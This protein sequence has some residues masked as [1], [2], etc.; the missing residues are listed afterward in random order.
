ML[1]NVNRQ[2]PLT[3]S[4]TTASPPRLWTVLFMSTK[5][6]AEP[7]YLAS[8]YEC[9]SPAAADAMLGGQLPGYVYARDGHPNAAS[10]AEQCRVYHGAACAA[11]T[12]SGMSAMALALLTQCVTGDHVL[13]SNQLYGRSYAL[14]VGE[15]ARLGIE[16][17]IVD[18]TDPDA[19]RAAWQPNTRMLVVETITNPL[20][21]VN[22]LAGLASLTHE[23]G[24]LLLVDNTLA[25][26]LNCQPHS[27]GA[28][29]V[30]ESLTKIM[31]GH[32]DVLLGLL[33][34]PKHLWDRVPATLSTWGWT[35]P[36]FES[37]L[38]A[39]GL[40][41]LPL[42]WQQA[43]DNALAIAA[44]LTKQAGIDAVHFPGLATHA[45]HALAVRQFAVARNTAGQVRCG[46]LVTFTLAGGW[47][48]ATN[49]I[50]AVRETIPFCPSLGE[51][52][53]TLSHPASTSHRA[54]TPTQRSGLGIED[55]TIRLSVGIENAEQ[56]QKH[57]LA[58]LK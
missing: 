51:L 47:D 16:S 3:L 26:P 28:D 18:T 50:A 53:T 6:H 13:L 14:F 55:G 34:G 37:W 11:V 45:D 2:E 7:I 54:L 30:V 20:L 27:L 21:R 44:W 41:T 25:G 4:S 43:A 57:L 35:A 5:P 12:N 22:D 9:E 19:V 42:R 24:G 1:G 29:L 23:R 46:T 40:Q 33:C 31:N 8:V 15:A 56:I 36:P 48:A 10:L 58:G 52:H 49:F 32:S 39:R 17:S 38:A